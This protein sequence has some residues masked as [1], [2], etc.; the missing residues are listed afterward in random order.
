MYEHQDA[1]CSSRP[2]TNANDTTTTTTATNTTTTTNDSDVQVECVCR[3]SNNHTSQF[4]NG[5]NKCSSIGTLASEPVQPENVQLP[6]PPLLLVPQPTFLTDRFHID[7][8]V[9]VDYGAEG[10][11]RMYLHGQLGLRR[12]R[13]HAMQHDLRR[14]LRFTTIGATLL[15]NAMAAKKVALR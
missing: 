11:W 13:T 9:E 6:P 14:F 3:V 2:S 8:E 7:M 12:R 10:F 15:K 5:T 4:E 1:G